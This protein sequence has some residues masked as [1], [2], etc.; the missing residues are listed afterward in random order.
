MPIKWR[1]SDFQTIVSSYRISLE[2]ELELPANG[3]TAMD[4]LAGKLTLDV[5]FFAHGNFRLP[6]TTFLRDLLLT[7]GL[8]ITQVHPLRMMRIRQFEFYCRTQGMIPTFEKLNVF[9]KLCTKSSS[10]GFHIRDTEVHFAWE[11]CITGSGSFFYVCMDII[12][13][14][15]SYCDPTSKIDDLPLMDYKNQYWYKL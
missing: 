13:I 11:A 1:E 15:M 3:N 9:Y 4:A 10:F 12:H 6:V 8:H 5:D 14:P 7:Y 2:W